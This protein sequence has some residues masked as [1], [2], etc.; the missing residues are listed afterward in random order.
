MITFSSFLEYPSQ[1]TSEMWAI[2]KMRR[3]LEANSHVED[4]Q[5]ENDNE[6]D[7]NEDIQQNS[8]QFNEINYYELNEN[9]HHHLEYSDICYIFM[10]LFHKHRITKDAQQDILKTMAEFRKRGVNNCPESLY[11]LMLELGKQSTEINVKRR[12]F[13]CQCS[14]DFEKIDDCN[15]NSRN[16]CGI[17]SFDLKDSLSH[18]VKNNLEDILKGQKV[19]D[20]KNMQDLRNGR[21]YKNLGHSTDDLMLSLIVSFDDASIYKSSRIYVSPISIIIA[22]LPN[23]L[24][25]KRKNVYLSSFWVG[26]MKPDMLNL[27]KFWKIGFG[28]QYNTLM[29]SS[30]K[31]LVGNTEYSFSVR[32]L[33]VVCDKVAKAS[34]LFHTQHNGYYGCVNCLIRGEWFVR[35][36]EP[37]AS[38]GSQSRRFKKKEKGKLVYPHCLNPKY[39][40]KNYDLPISGED[41]R[42]GHSVLLENDVNIPSQ[43]VIGK[44]YNMIL[45]EYLFSVKTSCIADIWV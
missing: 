26:K 18:L 8:Q 1:L 38:E 27:Q 45:Q 28:D 21:V 22:E 23:S 39:A 3:V 13:C 2:K 30:L 7:E 43:T 25:K 20:K 12:I 11:K 33:G 41:G 16:K 31:V 5:R 40:P 32:I 35:P 37:E 17:H 10:E 34:L 6:G 14:Q 36:E 24:R 15:C 4:L 19:Q 42:K 9:L 29:N 44:L